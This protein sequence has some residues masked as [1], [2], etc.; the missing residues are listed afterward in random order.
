MREGRD[1]VNH[2]A[3][4]LA[5]GI[6]DLMLYYILY[7]SKLIP[8]WLSGWGFIGIALAMSA[9]LLLMFRFVVVITPTYI[10]LTLPWALQQMVLAVWLIFRGFNPF[11]TVFGDD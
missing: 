10:I 7:R 2:V 6:G 11:A 1:L 8:R 5:L 3:L 4:F 9:S